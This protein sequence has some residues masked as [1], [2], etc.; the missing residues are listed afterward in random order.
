MD[1]EIHRYNYVRLVRGGNVTETPDGDPT[2]YR[3]DRVVV[4]P[5]G[6]TSNVGG[7]AGGPGGGAGG[8]PDSAAAAQL[9]VTEDGNVAEIVQPMTACDAFLDNTTTHCDA[10]TAF[11]ESDG[12]PTTHNMMVGIISWQQQVPLPQAYTG[13]NAW[14]IPL[15]PELSDNPI[16]A[17]TDMFR[18][19]IA[20]AV[21]GVPIFNALNN[22]GDDAYLA[23]ELD[24]GADTAVGQTIIITT[25][26][27]PIYKKWS[28]PIIPLPTRWMAIRSMV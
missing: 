22:R 16:S 2:A 14:Q 7:G 28:A 17:A 19:A 23:G 21:N 26:P 15:D 27:Q 25:L 24:H 1:P 10:D 13:D 11:V 18:G 5:D 4:F 3:T 8:P 12:L 20:L 6:D 9:G